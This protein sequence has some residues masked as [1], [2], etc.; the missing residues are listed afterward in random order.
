[1]PTLKKFS[2]NRES[3]SYDR[4]NDKIITVVWMTSLSVAKVGGYSVKDIKTK[5][6]IKIANPEL[7]T[8]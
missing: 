6:K 2:Q 1:M 3:E 8:V 4:K 7:D 5:S